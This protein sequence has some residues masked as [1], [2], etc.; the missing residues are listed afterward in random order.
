MKSHR[1]W[2][3]SAWL[4]VAAGASLACGGEFF[5]APNGKAENDGSREMPWDLAT[6]LA[7]P[8]AVKPNDTIWLRGGTYAGGL[9]S[10][11]QGAPDKVIVVRQLPGERATIDCLRQGDKTGTFYV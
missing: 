9:T 1:S 8:P 7:H 4:I 10:K 3:G 5:V 11:L 2:L 6:A